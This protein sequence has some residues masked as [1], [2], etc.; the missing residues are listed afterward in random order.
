MAASTGVMMRR[1]PCPASAASP[2]A[3]PIGRSRP[4][5]LPAEIAPRLSDDAEPPGDSSSSSSSGPP[6]S[7]LLSV[8]P[9]V[10]PAPAGAPN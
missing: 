4:S 5:S 2:P 10:A 6:D 3:S 7:P 1:L 8:A 9:P